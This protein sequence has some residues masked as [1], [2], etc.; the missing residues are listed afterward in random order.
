MEMAWVAVGMAGERWEVL[1]GLNNWNG[2]GEKM[3][4]ISKMLEDEIAKSEKYFITHGG[5]KIGDGFVEMTGEMLKSPHVVAT[6]MLGQLFST[7][8]QRDL[9][10]LLKSDREKGVN[11][12]VF[13]RLAAFPEVTEG[14]FSFLYWGMEIGRKLESEER[15]ALEGME[16]DGKAE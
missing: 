2:R 7:F 8:A 11:T 1:N 14:E 13:E 16:N 10:E 6:L 3:N 15:K 4:S 9:T 5:E 12:G